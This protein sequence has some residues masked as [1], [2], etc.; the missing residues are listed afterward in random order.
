MLMELSARTQERVQS[1][2]VELIR[3]NL[4]KTKKKKEAS[5]DDVKV[6]IRYQ[7]ES[8]NPRCLPE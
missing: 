5:A 1:L 3:E 6:N 4:F 2:K 7:A 8:I